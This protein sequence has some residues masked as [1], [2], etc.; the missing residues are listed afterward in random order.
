MEE[1]LAGAAAASSQDGAVLV[2][3]SAE[4]EAQ[5]VEPVKKKRKVP[6]HVPKEMRA[7]FLEYAEM[8]SRCAG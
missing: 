5:K 8:Q 4:V 2:D 3:D 6:V 1:T 7:W